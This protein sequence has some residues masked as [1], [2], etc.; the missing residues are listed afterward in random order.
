NSRKAEIQAPSLVNDVSRFTEIID[1][2]VSR[3]LVTL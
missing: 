2:A 1:I 3:T